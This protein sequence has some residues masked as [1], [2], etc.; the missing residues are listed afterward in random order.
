MPFPHRKGPSSFDA[1]VRD[2]GGWRAEKAE[3]SVLDAGLCEMCG[4]ETNRFLEDRC[5][6][7][8]R[9]MHGYDDGQYATFGTLTREAGEALTRLIV[10]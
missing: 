7:C 2:H 3:P 1:Y 6:D 8:A 5:E 10:L 4:K 9:W